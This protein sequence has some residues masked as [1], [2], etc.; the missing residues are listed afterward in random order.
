MTRP[1][2]PVP[3]STPVQGCGCLMVLLIIAGCLIIL[4]AAFGIGLHIV[5]F[6]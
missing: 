4:G 5:G 2:R 3:A 1:L 6:R